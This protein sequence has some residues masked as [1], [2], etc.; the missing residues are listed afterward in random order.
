MPYNCLIEMY[1]YPKDDPKRHVLAFRA[2][3]LPVIPPR[4]SELTGLLVNRNQ[5]CVVIGVSIDVPDGS[6]TLQVE[7][8]P[9]FY[10][11][12]I[13]EIRSLLAPDW[14]VDT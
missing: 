9:N 10:N 5:A 6:I 12:T 1:F 8:P 13:D 3:D 2:D 14:H 4:E 11:K 7:P